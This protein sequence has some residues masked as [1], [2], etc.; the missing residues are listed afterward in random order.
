MIGDDGRGVC[1][2]RLVAQSRLWATRRY[3]QPL[4]SPSKV[5]PVPPFT[6][7]NS[8]HQAARNH[9]FCQTESP[10]APPPET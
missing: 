7:P 2:Y 6:A 1:N 3:L 9:T 5:M 10:P 8:R 4:V